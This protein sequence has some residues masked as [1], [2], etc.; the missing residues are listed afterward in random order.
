MTKQKQSKAFISYRRVGNKLEAMRSRLVYD[1]ARP[2]HPESPDASW[3]VSPTRVAYGQAVP[4]GEV[5]GGHCD[6]VAKMI[7]ARNEAIQ[8][9][10][11]G[12]KVPVAA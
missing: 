3:W 1:E 2:L 5:Y 7:E 10:R 6:R 11:N 8:A 12:K 9:R 4:W